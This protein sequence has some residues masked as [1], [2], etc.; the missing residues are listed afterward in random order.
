MSHLPQLRAIGIGRQSKKND[1]SLSIPLQIERLEQVAAA[2]NF[3]LLGVLEEPGVSGGADLSK[4]RGLRVAVEMVENDEADVIVAAYFDRFFRDLTV[5]AEVLDRIE[6]AGGRVL[7]ADVGDVSN[8]TASSWMSATAIGMVAEYHRRVTREKTSESRRAAIA[9]GVPASPRITPAYRRVFDAQGTCVGIE[10]HPERAPIVR[11]AFE[12]RAAGSSLPAIV[13]FLHEHGIELS[14]SG[15]QKL[16]ESRIVRGELRHGRYV[17]LE[18]HEPVV[19][20]ELWQAVQAVRGSRGRKA[21]SERLLARQRILRCETCGGP[22]SVRHSVGR[23]RDGTPAPHRVYAF[24]VCSSPGR[25]DGPRAMIAADAA[26]AIVRAAVV[27]KTSGIVGRAGLIDELDSLDAQLAKLDRDLEAAAKTFEGF[28]NMAAV[29]ERMLELQSRRDELS[30][31]RAH[32]SRV[33]DPALTVTTEDDFDQLTLDGR[34]ELVRSYVARAVVTPGH[35][36]GRFRRSVEHRVRVEFTP[37]AL[38]Q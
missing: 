33:A 34:R 18:S 37:E 19:S 4:R 7:A 14:H 21:K 35:G 24:Y 13:D 11:R 27:S 31:R 38:A 26:E 23:N 36:T 15:L 22:M 30:A 1:E 3:N 20:E 5:Q 16:F 29:R 10:P 8:E 25:H 17:K 2:E 12:L 28:E 32:L 6:K 9:R